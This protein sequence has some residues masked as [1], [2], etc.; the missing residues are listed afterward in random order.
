MKGFPKY[1]N[2]KEDYLFVV[3]NDMDREKT[4]QALNALLATAKRK[5]PVW[6]DG[7]DPDAVL[8]NPTAEPVEP[9]DWKEVDDPNGR[10][11][12]LG[13]TIEEVNTLLEIV[14]TVRPFQDKLVQLKQ[15]IEEQDYSSAEEMRTSLSA[16][17]PSLLSDIGL[18]DMLESLKDALSSRNKTSALQIIENAQGQ[19][20]N[21][22]KNTTKEG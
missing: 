12:R 11:F 6:P 17:I 7:Y 20:E 8:D 10:I 9:V 14:K 3:K 5:E 1:F 2:S 13:F 16:E 18:V 22:I 21:F 4:I 15:L 19:V